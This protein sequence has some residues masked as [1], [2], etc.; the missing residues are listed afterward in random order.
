MTTR[1]KVQH[2]GIIDGSLVIT[3]QGRRSSTQSFCVEDS[4]TT[5]SDISTDGMYVLNPTATAINIRCTISRVMHCVESFTSPSRRSLT[6]NPEGTASTPPK[7]PPRVG[8]VRSGQARGDQKLVKL[9][10]FHTLASIWSYCMKYGH[11]A[12][13]DHVLARVWKPC[14]SSGHAPF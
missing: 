8:P 12:I 4:T 1:N 2:D 5:T 7:I 14:N 9:G 3:A 6:R 10:S 13:I 11:I